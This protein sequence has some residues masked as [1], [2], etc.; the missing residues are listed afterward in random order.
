MFR[1]V[2][3][4]SHAS[5]FTE[6]HPI[7]GMAKGP[8]GE[9]FKSAFSCFVFSEAEPKGSDCV[10]AFQAMQSC[11]QDYPE[12]YADQL[13]EDEKEGEESGPGD[14]E[15]VNQQSSLEKVESS[16]APAA[17]DDRRSDSSTEMVA[18]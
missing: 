2:A 1:Y 17:S 10:S 6:F 9:E 16:S 13:R 14:R 11:F 3:R 12:Y 4:I 7:G 8:C 18:A 15:V 5:L